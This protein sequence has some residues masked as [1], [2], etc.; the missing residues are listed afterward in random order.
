MCETSLR[1][2]LR[3]RLFTRLQQDDVLSG[4]HEGGCVLFEKRETVEAILQ[5]A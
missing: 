3:S 4:E 5:E 1:E 2:A